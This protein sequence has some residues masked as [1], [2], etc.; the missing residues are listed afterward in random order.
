MARS[1][2]LSISACK[3]AVCSS[4]M[5]TNRWERIKT[6]N[7]SFRDRPIERF[8]W[9]LGLNA[10]RKDFLHEPFVEKNGF[11]CVLTEYRELKYR[12]YL[13]ANNSPFTLD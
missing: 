10:V 9:V 11:P 2:L 7:F 12:S 8:R 4:G 1:L 13:V 3:M 6:W 5:P